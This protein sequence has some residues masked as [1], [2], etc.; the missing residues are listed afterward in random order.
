[1]VLFLLVFA[2]CAQPESG[3]AGGESAGRELG[4]GTVGEIELVATMETSTPVDAVPSP[5]GSS[6]Y[7][8]IGAPP[9]IFRTT[10]EV[11]RPEVVTDGAGFEL[12]W[13]LSISSDG[14]RIYTAD[15]GANGEGRISWLPSA[16]GSPTTVPGTEGTDARGVEVVERDGVDV[17]YFTG[18]DPADSIPAVFSVPSDGGERTVL[19]K[20]EPLGNP[21]AIAVSGDGT[22][23]V[24]DRPLAGG[25]DNVYRLGEDGPESLLHS[26][27]LGVPAGVAV[28]EDDSTLLVSSI[29]ATDGTA[30]LLLLDL[31]SG[32]TGIVDKVIGEN[33]SAGGLHRAHDTNVFAWADVTRNVYRF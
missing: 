32:D 27:V 12:I 5:D 10:D 30:Q 26:V 19:A 7:F 21:D 14:S 16:G 15:S 8:T 4:N 3:Q 20:G 17:V 29:D 18:K 23:Y 1:M 33:P 6:V 11:G 2:A 25:E 28:T 24:S 13:S 31:E 9:V 22:V